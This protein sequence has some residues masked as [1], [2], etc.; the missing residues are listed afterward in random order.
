M[1]AM[2]TTPM[3]S[4]G[5]VVIPETIRQQLRLREGDQFVVVGD[6]DTIV[7]KTVKPPSLEGLE[8][9]MRKA[10]LQALTAGMKPRDV[11]RGIRKVRGQK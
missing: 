8:G 2:A 1:R 10:T 3:S 7:L 9:L 11:S 6:H 5:Q 4:K